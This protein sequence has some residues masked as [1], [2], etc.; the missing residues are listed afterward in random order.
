M[1]RL[2]SF[3]VKNLVIEKMILSMQEEEKGKVCISVLIQRQEN[4]EYK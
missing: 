3:D 2:F 4:V 1:K